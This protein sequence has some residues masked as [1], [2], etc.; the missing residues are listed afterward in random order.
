M[1]FLNQLTKS[2]GLSLR[3]FKN[4]AS[5]QPNQMN[6]AATSRTSFSARR[7]SST[8]PAKRSAI[9]YSE[10]LK[11]YRAGSLGAFA[12][13]FTDY[14]P[15]LW[16]R[17]PFDRAL[18]ERSF[19]LTVLTGRSNRLGWNSEEFARGLKAVSWKVGAANG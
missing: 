19:R 13:C 10:V 1:P 9:Y 6:R 8:S 5:A 15:S 14:H 16:D 3:C 18:R 17:P 4:S 7:N 2:L 11:L 12:W